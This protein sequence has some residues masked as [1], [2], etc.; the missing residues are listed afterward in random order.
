MKN[1]LAVLILLL[2]GCS[3]APALRRDDVE[4]ALRARQPQLGG[5]EL[6]VADANRGKRARLVRIAVSQ[7]LTGPAWTPE[8]IQ[9]INAWERPLALAGV[10]RELVVLPAGLSDDCVAD[11]C[12]LESQRQAATIYGADA[13]LVLNSETRVEANANF[14]APLDATLLGLLIIPAHQRQGLTLVEATLVDNRDRE[15]YAVAR[16]EGL[17]RTARPWVYA[18]PSATE[19]RSRVLALRHLGRELVEAAAQHR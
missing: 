3:S 10:G 12:P 19:A 6:A 13:L 17:E 15:V 2:A 11:V 8:E 9:E 5:E 7:P 16:G 4:T 14:L 1:V 18:D